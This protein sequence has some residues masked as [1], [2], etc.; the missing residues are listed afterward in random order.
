MAAINASRKIHNLDAFIL[1]R[2]DAYIGVL[3][4]DL[5]TKNPVEP[6][7]MF[8]SR[9]E[10]RLL[11]RFDNADRRL[12]HFGYTI[13]LLPEN[14]YNEIEFRKQ[15]INKCINYAK[16]T[17]YSP[18]VINPILREKGENLIDHGFTLDKIVKRQ[19]IHF[20]DCI[21]LLPDQLQKDV[22]SDNRIADQ[23]DTDI[24][25]EGYIKRNLQ[26]LKSLEK[27]ESMSIPINFDYFSL[28]TITNE[29]REKLDK[30][31][32]ETIGQASRIPGVSPADI[33]ALSIRL[34]KH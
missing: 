33:T 34:K 25:Y 10:Y 31:K 5:V 22:L 4:D 23:V 28:N 3:I 15:V 17:H 13:G 12:G 21:H 29:A 2:G 11:L 32:P 9:A 26:L 6:Y 24:K 20:S 7:R 14:I 18:K 30:I 27:H 16:K 19:K 8:T 1:G